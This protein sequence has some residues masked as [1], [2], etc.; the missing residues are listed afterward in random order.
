LRCDYDYLVLHFSGGAD[1]GNILETFINNKIHL[2]EVLVRGSFNQTNQSSGIVSAENQYGECLTQ[3][4]PL[5]QWAKDT[6]MP[7]LK[8]TLVE[9]TEIINNYFAKTPDW[10]E[11]NVISL[12]PGTAFKSELDSVSPHY[13]ELADRGLR[14]AHIYGTDKPKIYKNKN[15]FYTRWQDKNLATFVSS[16]ITNSPYPQYIECFYYGKH[17]V[18]LQ[19][20]QLHVLKNYIKEKNLPDWM[21]DVGRARNYENFVASIIYNRT[22]PLITVHAKPKDISVIKD[23]DAW[24][25]QDLYSDSYQN[26]KKGIEYLGVVLPQFWQNRLDDSLC[27]IKGLWSKPR[28]LGS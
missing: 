9:T 3:S 19:I 11:N 28:N 18:K 25:S 21:F 17:S 15:T 5:A 24:F 13:K 23:M 12:T 1:S 4:I 27:G 2:D 10:I 7:H 14:V 6:H 8:I 22:M 16:R 20:K 26:Y